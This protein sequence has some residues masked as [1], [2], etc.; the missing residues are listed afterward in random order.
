M[1]LTAHPFIVAAELSWKQESLGRANLGGHSHHRR[2]RGRG[3]HLPGALHGT[4]SR[5]FPQRPR[6][7]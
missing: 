7:A 6:P 2:P 5:R 3:W 1:S 4:A